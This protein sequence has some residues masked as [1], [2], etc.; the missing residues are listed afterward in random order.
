MTKKQLMKQKYSVSYD[1]NQA[2]S[3]IKTDKT[4]KTIVYPLIPQN[5]K[6][7]KKSKLTP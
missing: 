2:K 7:T 4:S 6:L 1:N 3:Y 5:L